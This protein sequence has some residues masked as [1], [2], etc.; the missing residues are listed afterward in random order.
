M[1]PKINSEKDEY[2]AIV[3]STYEFENDLIVFSSNR[4]GGSGGFDLYYAGIKIDNLE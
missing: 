3:I 1:G 4:D 2:R